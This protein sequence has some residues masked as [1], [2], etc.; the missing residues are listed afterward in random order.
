MVRVVTTENN[1]SIAVEDTSG[2]FDT[3]FVN[4]TSPRADAWETILT[5]AD[6]TNCDRGT[7]ANGDEF[8][9]CEREPAGG[10]SFDVVYVVP[11]EIDVLLQR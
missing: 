11:T 8:V 3:L 9:T 6:F 2:T 10:G 5:D 1:R 7:D 4:V